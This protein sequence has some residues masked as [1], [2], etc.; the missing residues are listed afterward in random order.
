MIVG[1]VGATG[2]S[3]LIL[4][5]H[6]LGHP[7]VEQLILYGR[8]E[9]PIGLNQDPA[10]MTVTQDLSIHTFTPEQIMTETDVVFFATSA[11]VTSQLAG[12]FI[13]KKFPV[14][15]LSG[16]LRLKDPEVYEKWYHKE[17]A[18]SVDLKQV[19]YGLADCVKPS[20]HYV[21]NPGCYATATIEAL[22]PLVAEDLVAL[23]TIIADAKSGVS[24]A[25][26]KLTTGSHFI[27][28]DENVSLYKV[29][30]HQ[31]IPEIVQAL[32]GWNAEFKALQFTTTLLPI[33]RGIMVTNY[34]TLHHDLWS[35]TPTDIEELLKQSYQKY[36]QDSPFVILT[37][38]QLPNI[39]DVVGSNL[40]AIGWVYNPTT[41]KV[42]AVSVIDNLLKGAAGQAIQ[43]FNHMFQFDE[44][45]GLPS[46]PNLI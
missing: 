27:N 43:N 41:H 6:L 31:H 38:K 24:G 42:L 26:K 34:A 32:Q 18:S 8:Q 39:T 19:D 29:N 2:Y 7:Q 15:D 16:D 17:A 36:Y 1:I 46:I 20:N 21:A 11:G 5:K 22:L 33:K 25:G 28:A 37:G 3:G 13:A 44:T 23:D 9:D 35:K 45:L 40:T 10:F 12:A 14:I 30:E 4:L